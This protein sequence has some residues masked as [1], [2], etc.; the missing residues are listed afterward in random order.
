MVLIVLVK[1]KRLEIDTNLKQNW[2]V[3]VGTP[4]ESFCS[5]KRSSEKCLRKLTRISFPLACCFEWNNVTYYSTHLH[6]YVKVLT[7]KEVMCS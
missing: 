4:I 5:F 1:S 7:A 6:D 2:A 3:C